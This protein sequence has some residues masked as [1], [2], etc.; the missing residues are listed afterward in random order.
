MLRHDD[1]DLQRGGQ[2]V[3]G[4]FGV[5]EAA[6]INCTPAAAGAVGL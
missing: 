1:R 2:A 6:V 4:D 5:G 3:T